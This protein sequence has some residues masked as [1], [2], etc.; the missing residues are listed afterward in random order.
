MPDIEGE[1]SS[2]IKKRLSL[3]TKRSFVLARTSEVDRESL[4]RKVTWTFLVIK[5]EFIE[6]M[7]QH[8]DR[9]DSD[10]V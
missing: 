8:D 4:D 3:K 2:T 7:K 6:A 9:F 5:T 1:M 10:V